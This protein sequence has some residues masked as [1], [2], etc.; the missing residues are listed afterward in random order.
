MFHLYFGAFDVVLYLGGAYSA[1]VLANAIC[2]RMDAADAAQ[3]AARET[4]PELAPMQP[5][6]PSLAVPT[7]K[8][9]ETSVKVSLN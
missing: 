7:K 3:S 4:R 5:I 6:D 8:A 9:E 1:I 2:D